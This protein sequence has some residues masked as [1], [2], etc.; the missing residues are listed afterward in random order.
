MR[1]ALLFT[2]LV[3]RALAAPSLSCGTDLCFASGLSSGAVL[4]RAPSRAAL[5]GSVHE[6][7]SPGSTVIVTLASSD[8]TFSKNFTGRVNADLTWKVILDP[9]Q[10][11]GN[12]SATASCASCTGGKTSKITDLTFGGERRRDVDSTRAQ[13]LFAHLT[14]RA[15]LLTRTHSQM[16]FFVRVSQICGSPSG[17]LL[18][19][20]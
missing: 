18:S 6:N 4:Q 5:F 3:A 20:M 17:L 10:T 9:I 8:G 2:A 7:S 11:G 14:P 13:P 12:Y 15:T 1:S 19:G 16:S